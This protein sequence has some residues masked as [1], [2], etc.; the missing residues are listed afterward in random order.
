MQSDHQRELDRILEAQAITAKYQ[1]LV[2]LTSMAVVGYEALARGPKGSSL[3]RPDHLFSVARKANR[4]KQLDWICRTVAVRG[5]LE[6]RLRPPLALFVNSEP[7]T[8][9]SRMPAAFA[10]SW[11][12]ARL[13]GVRLIFEV[14]ERAVMDRPAEL[15]RAVDQIRRFGWGVALDDVGTNPASLALL[16][17]LDPD[18]IKLDMRPAPREGRRRR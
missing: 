12:R 15:L 7:E 2:S 10:E 4:L 1:P 6:S 14:T 3:E 8:I 5:A 13:A 16:P 11:G 18:V 9:G 17:F